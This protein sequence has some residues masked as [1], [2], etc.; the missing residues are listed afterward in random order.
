MTPDQ[1]SDI[2]SMRAEAMTRQGEVE[3]QEDEMY[4][5]AAPKG[6]FTG[7]AANA[8]VDATN[9]LLPL[10][11]ITDL[12]D[13]FTEPKMTALPPEFARLLTM[14]GTA[15]DDAI[16][17]GVLPEDAKIDLTIVT[18]DAG[19]Q[20][21][22][23]RIGMAAKSSQFKRFLSKKVTERGAEEMGK[24]GEYSES[25]PASDMMSEDST[26]TLFAGRM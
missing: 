11:G 6:K 21:L 10:F 15:F 1:K 14:F 3:A 18:D 25:E 26:N 2:E 16:E 24:E 4:S 22:A 8:L 9:K 17:A 23:G 13:K 19:L 7:K 12:Y 5:S 20:G